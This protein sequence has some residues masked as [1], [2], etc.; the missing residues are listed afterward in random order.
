MVVKVE[1]KSVSGSRN[2]IFSKQYKVVIAA[3]IMMISVL[4]M[5][6]AMTLHQ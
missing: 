3:L 6:H 1:K 4:G 5:C 2:I